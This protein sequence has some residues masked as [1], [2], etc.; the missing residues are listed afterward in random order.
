VLN[1]LFSDDMDNTRFVKP[2]GNSK[3]SK[4]SFLC[5]VYFRDDN[6]GRLN[7]CGL[8]DAPKALFSA[9]EASH[10]AQ[11]R[12]RWTEPRRI[13]FTLASEVETPEGERSETH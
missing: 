1:Q 7:Y 11:S 2:I 3:T 4:T 9:S 12:S 8:A 10:T 6:S 5:K 13:G